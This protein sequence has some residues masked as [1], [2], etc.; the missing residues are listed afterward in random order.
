MLGNWNEGVIDILKTWK[1]IAETKINMCLGI[2]I[3]F[4]RT[5]LFNTMVAR[6]FINNE[7]DFSTVNLNRPTS[8]TN[9]LSK[10]SIRSIFNLTGILYSAYHLWNSNRKREL[11]IKAFKLLPKYLEAKMRGTRE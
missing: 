4:P 9:K 1:L 10:K 6:G 8:R 5:E 7:I 3:P 2:V 11:F